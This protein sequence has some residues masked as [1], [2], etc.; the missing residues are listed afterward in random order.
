MSID[1]NGSRWVHLTPAGPLLTRQNS[2]WRKWGQRCSL[3]DVVWLTKVSVSPWSWTLARIDCSLKVCIPLF[4]LEG[5]FWQKTN[6]KSNCAELNVHSRHNWKMVFSNYDFPHLDAHIPTVL[7][8]LFFSIQAVWLTEWMQLSGKK[9]SYKTLVNWKQMLHKLFVL[10]VCLGCNIN[11]VKPQTTV[12]S[13]VFVRKNQ[14]L[15]TSV[16]NT[17]PTCHR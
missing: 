15:L 3:T 11:D 2:R 13:P 8:L 9:C 10:L 16:S 5:L 7:L 1:Q 14:C 17:C 6:E 12:W 4:M